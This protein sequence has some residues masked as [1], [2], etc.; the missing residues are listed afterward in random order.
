MEFILK[1]NPEGPGSNHLFNQDGDILA[2]VTNPHI[3][4]THADLICHPRQFSMNSVGLRHE[5]TLLQKHTEITHKY[6]FTRLNSN[7]V[8]RYNLLTDEVDTISNTTNENGEYID[9][10]LYLKR[11]LK[12][13]RH[14]IFGSQQGKEIWYGAEMRN[15]AMAATMWNEIETHTDLLRENHCRFPFSLRERSA[16]LQLNCTGVKNGTVCDVSVPT[17]VER[18]NPLT[19]GTNDDNIIAKRR[20][21]VPY[22]DLSTELGIDIDEVRNR[23]KEVDARQNVSMAERHHMDDIHVDKVAAGIIIL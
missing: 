12:S 2:T 11:R 22:W 7:E 19:D 3:H 16:F 23:E 9:V 13:D 10:A 14:K 8:E 15:E 21:R 1:I 17:C 6:K 5:G 20:W 4:L 18:R